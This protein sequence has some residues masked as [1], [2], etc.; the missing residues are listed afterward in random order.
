[1]LEFRPHHFLC[2][3]GFEGKGYSDEFVRGY[4]EIADRLRA[5]GAEGDAT[6]IRVTGR[7]DSICAPC[8]NRMGEACATEGKI[9]ALDHGHA[10]VLGLSPG[11]EL[12]WGEAKARIAEKM[13]DAD[14]ERV[15]APCSWKA[16]GV[17]QKALTRNREE[18]AR[19]Q[20]T[21]SATSSA[22]QPLSPKKPALLACG[23]F[24][25][26][27]FSLLGAS[28]ALIP[29]S[30]HAS[31][32]REDDETATRQRPLDQVRAELPKKHKSKTA[33]ALKK[34]WESLQAKKYADA[35]RLASPLTNDALFGDYGN[36]IVASA[37]YNTALQALE[38]KR[39]GEALKA[40]ESSVIATF[41][42][43]T[44]SPYSPM[45]KNL[46]REV[47]LAEVVQGD[48]HAAQKKWKPAAKIYEQG[49]QRLALGNSLGLLRPE[50]LQAYA[51]TCATLKTE[52]CDA[53][54]QR[55]SFFYPRNSEEMRAITQVLP[56]AILRPRPAF[57]G[58][59]TQSYKAPDLDQTA[60]EQNMELYLDGKFGSAIRGFQQFIDEYP[61][62][63]YRF[64]VRYWLA[65]AMSHEQQHEKAQAAY[66]S[67][68]SDSPLTYYGLLSAFAAGH[69]MDAPI[70]PSVPLVTTRD[71]LLQPSELQRVQRAEHFITEGA[72]DLALMELK[73]FRS[74]DA[75][76]SPFL[77]YLAALTTEARAYN[78]AFGILSDLIARNYRAATSAQ[79]LS[80]IF[81]VEYL[82]EIR[83]QATA[84]DLDP[85]LVL[86]LI[87][88]E[89]AFDKSAISSA[90]ALGLMQLMPATASDTDPKV[91][92]ADLVEPAP[93]I[94]VGA[95]YLKKLLTRF[96]GN[97]VLALA[98]YNA[99]PNAAE[100]WYREQGSKRG[101]I[102]FIETIPYRE[103]REYVSAIVRNYYWY[104]R[105]LTP[106][107]PAKPLS[108]FW[109]PYKTPTPAATPTEE[110]APAPTATL[111]PFPAASLLPV[112][113]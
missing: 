92:R 81:P 83:K 88:Q 48:A 63:P 74:R 61:K 25:A 87:K 89:S 65:Q 108:F 49:F 38:K 59:L 112:E 93:N 50:T 76:S 10:A 71:P 62:S 5:T 15:C 29:A 4:R 113:D 105:K 73:E 16:L 98:G 97:I 68:Q 109:A 99:G 55:F 84:L 26:A 1:M 107:E 66:E 42:I 24:L 67:L 82:D 86:G 21:R 57:A 111:E 12:S 96:N 103:T 2:T 54:V 20:Q 14:F 3:L 60:F 30:A 41:R 104:S 39:Y 37:Q 17:C 90:G 43:E 56:G 36:W 13:N 18:H 28:I 45:L 9:Q 69:N 91:A 35:I 52:M 53:W 27:A 102:D 101:M 78:A 33:R 75:L 6:V 34:A 95:K 70:D 32:V 8:P 79:C 44:R 110:P 72:F 40:A 47:G 19:A 31:I 11:Q 85:I 46:N 58:K 106:G 94:R 80:M 7:T 51:K 77:M 23:L 100:R 64:R 22:C